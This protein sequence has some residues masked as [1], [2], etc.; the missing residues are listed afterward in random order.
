MLSWTLAADQLGQQ[1]IPAE[2]QHRK[3]LLV[4]DATQHMLHGI[5]LQCQVLVLSWALGTDKLG[6]QLIPA[7]C[8]HRKSLLVR[9]VTQQ[10][11]CNRC[12]G[13]ATEGA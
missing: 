9:D 13:A 8:Q 1:L 6:Q 4:R 3:S 5:C 12:D 7:D 2:C 10:Q 11:R